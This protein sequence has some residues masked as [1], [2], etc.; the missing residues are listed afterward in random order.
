MTPEAITG[1]GGVRIG[2]R[3]LRNWDSGCGSS[4]LLWWTSEAEHPQMFRWR[5]SVCEVEADCA[6][7]RDSTGKAR[8]S[9][10]V[11]NEGHGRQGLVDPQ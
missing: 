5:F 3:W 1:Y 2:Q 10:S 8:S 11:R 7:R 6:V 9:F 4:A